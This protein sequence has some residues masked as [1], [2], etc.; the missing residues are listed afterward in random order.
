MADLGDLQNRLNTDSALRQQFFKD[1][2]D[3][4]KKEGISLSPQMER[5]LKA[6]VSQTQSPKPPVAGSSIAG[7]AAGPGIAIEISKNF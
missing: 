5:D 3:V 6:L 4:L 2:I 1:P 7:P